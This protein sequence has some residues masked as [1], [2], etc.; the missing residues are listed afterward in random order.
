MRILKIG[1][2]FLIQT[3]ANGPTAAYEQVLPRAWFTLPTNPRTAAAAPHWMR[4]NLGAKAER[5]PED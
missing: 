4:I 3:F 1:P 5:V 2:F